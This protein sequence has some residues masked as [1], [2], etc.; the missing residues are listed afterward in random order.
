MFP[1]GGVIFREGSRSTCMYYVRSG[2]VGIYSGYGTD[3]AKLLTTLE[4]GTFFGEMGMVRGF[5]RSATAVALAPNTE[6]ETVTWETLSGY[7]RTE[8]AKVVGIMQ[9]MANRIAEL[10]DDYIGAC[11][12]ITRLLEERPAPRAAKPERREKD[13]ARLK[14]YV[15]AY[16]RYQSSRYEESDIFTRA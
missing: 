1:Q 3:G 15:D 16:R 6:I 9:Q 2:R 10:T 4:P 5:P 14:K 13:S 8:P 12:E 11:G 7:F